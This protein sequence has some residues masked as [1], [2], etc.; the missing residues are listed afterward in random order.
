MGAAGFWIAAVAS[1]VV[2]GVG[3]LAYFLRISRSR[4]E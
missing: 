4:S 3:V 2:A 1:L